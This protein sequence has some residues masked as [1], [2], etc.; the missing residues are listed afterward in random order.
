MTAVAQIAAGRGG[1]PPSLPRRSGQRREYRPGGLSQ[2]QYL[3]QY[4][5]LDQIQKQ[6]Q[7]APQQRSWANM[8]AD[9]MREQF[10]L[11]PKDSG[12]LYRHPYPEHFER[13]PLPNRYKVPDFSTFLG[14]DNVSTY[15]HK[16]DESVQ[17][18]IQ[19]FRD[20]RNRCFSLA[21]MD[22]QLADLAFQGL[23]APISEKFA[24][25]EFD[26][27][28]HLAQKDQNI[29]HAQNPKAN[30]LDMH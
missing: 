15:E 14:Q 29:W 30:F 27:L 25:Q 8:I 3:P 12:N 5:Q 21:L 11:K 13:V 20:M 16:H 7:G 19:R 9:V 24:A 10:G 26:S 23:L 28:A 18:Y 4:N 17:D 1:S 22:S 2:P 6:I